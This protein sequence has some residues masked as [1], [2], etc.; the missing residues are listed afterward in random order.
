MSGGVFTITE[1]RDKSDSASADLG[2]RFEWTSDDLPRGDVDGVSGGGA[3]A[4]PL[5]PWPI[6]L[7]QRNVKTNYPGAKTP[8][9]QILGTNLGVQTFR[10]RFDDRYNGD[11]YALNEKRRLE[12]MIGR[13][14]LVPIQYGPIV[15]EG[16]VTMA[17]F[18]VQRLWDI[19]YELTFD[20]DG[21]P[22]DK[23]PIRVP[24]TPSSTSA[25]L[26]RFDVAVQAMLDADVRAPRTQVAG[27]LADGITQDLVATTVAR[28]SHAATV[29]A[30]DFRPVERP[31]DAF[32][33]IA[34]RSE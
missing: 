18:D 29:D 11:R 28:N 8:S 23:D 31:T 13:G 20:P 10:G 6:T 34:T 5:K 26:D 33:R 3:R 7:E 32:T 4:C 22:E 27:T 12:D 2:E 19:D 9:R 16:L 30:R 17:K 24:Q 15:Y 25:L 1:L 21:K 14:N